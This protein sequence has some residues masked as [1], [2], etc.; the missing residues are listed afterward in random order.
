MDTI[1]LE[2]IWV[3]LLRQEIPIPVNGLVLRIVV[4]LIGHLTKLKKN[5]GSSG[6]V[7]GTLTNLEK[8]L[9]TS[10]E[11]NNVVPKRKICQTIKV[12]T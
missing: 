5:V 4:A 9:G 2:V 1:A 3:Q 10:L 7:L 12:C 6:H 8:M 11:Q